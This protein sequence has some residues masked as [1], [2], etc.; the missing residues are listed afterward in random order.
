[1]QGAQAQTL[2]YRNT[3]V[4]NVAG[5]YTDLGTTGTAISMANSDD[6]N[7]AAQNIG[8]SFSYNG[9]SFS[10]FVMNTN[11]AI[12]LGASPP[13][14]AGLYPT[15]GQDA[16]TGSPV[17]S[18]AAADVNLLLPFNFD[19]EAGTGTP[20]Y[21]VAVTGTSPNQVCTIQWKNVSD[22]VK[23]GVPKL[24][25]N[26]SFQI[27]LYEGSNNIEF[28]YDAP[29]LGTTDANFKAAV[30][31]IK[32]SGNG[33][34][35]VAL[36]TKG[37]N[38]AA[39]ATTFL[40]T[41]Y[42]ANGFNFRNNNP[43]ALIDAGRTFRFI[44]NPANDA[45]VLAVYTLNKLPIPV[46]VPHAV[47]AVIANQGSA[48]F[49]GKQATLTIT[50]ASN[51]VVFTNTKTLINAGAGNNAPVTFDPYSPT[52]A[53][54]YTVTVSVPS[55]GVNT[56][57]TLSETQVVNTTGDFSYIKGTNSSLRGFNPGTSV[58]AYAALYT[59]TTALTVNGVRSYLVDANPLAPATYA[60][61]VGKTVYAVLLDA[62]TGAVLGRSNDYVVQAG[63][64]NTLKSFTLQSPV[65]LPA[66]SFLVG[67]A[68]T[69]Q[70][71]QTQVYLPYGAQ[72]ETPSRTG[73]FFSVGISPSAAPT[74]LA[75]TATT[76]M[77]FEAIT[78]AAPA[79]VPP[80]GASAGSITSTGATISFTNSGTA[81][82]YT[83]TV[84][85]QGGSTS[86]VTPAP[87]T[88]PVVLTGLTP[89]TNYTVTI[90]SNCSGSTTSTDA[91]VSFATLYNN[92]AAV[93]IVYTQGQVPIPYG[94][95][96]VVTATVTN[97]GQ[98]TLTNLPVVLTVSGA[99]SFTNTQ[100]VAS[101]AAGAI[102]TV[103]FAG[104]TPTS[105]GTNS[106]VVTISDDNTSNNA[107]PQRQDV[108][109]TT[110]G[111]ATPGAGISSSVGFNT[112]TGILA[113]KFT[114]STSRVVSAVNVFLANSSTTTG[115]TVRAVVLDASGNIIGS[116]AD[117]VV[118]AADLN[119]LKSFTI[120]GT[121]IVPAGS[122]F[123]GLGQTTITGSGYFP[124]GTQNEAP[125]RAGAYFITALTGG[126]PTDVA[127]NNLGRFYIEAVTANLPAC[128]PVSG[129]TTSNVTGTSGDVSFTA[130]SSNTSYTLTY[131]PA[132]GGTPTTVTSS[133]LPISLTGLS[134]GTTYNLSVVS[135]C[136]GGTT[137]TAVTGTLSTVPA[138]D[139]CSAS[140]PLLTC[141]SS[142]TG[143]TRGSTS[144][145][146]PTGTF[147]GNQ[148]YASSGGVFYRF[149]GNG[150]QVTLSMCGSAA[151]YDSELFVFSG[152]CGSLT[153]VASDDDG[154]GGGGLS[155]VTFV[156]NVGTMYYVYVTGWNGNRGNFTLTATCTPL[157]DLVVSNTQGITGV[158]N[159]VT[160]T[161]TGVASMTGDLQVQNAMTVQTGGRLISD[162]TNTIVGAGSFTLAAGAELQICDP[163]GLENNSSSFL[164]VTGT[165]SFSNDANYV[166]NGTN[167]AQLTGSALPS[168]VRSL[169]VNNSDDLTLS[170]ALSVAQLARLQDGDL[171]TGGNTFTLLSSGAGTAVLD[172]TGG[173]VV[174]TGTMQRAITSGASI[175]YRH[176]SSPVQ[177]TTVADLTAPGFTPVV[178]AAYNTDAD[179][180][181]VSPFPTVFGYNQDRIATVTSPYGSFDKGWFSPASLT[182]V[183]QPTRGYTANVPT[184][185]LV[186]F[187]GTFNNGAMPSGTLNRGTDPEAGWHLLG[188]PYPS[189][190]DW[191]TVTNAQRP[192]MDGA[193][194]VYTATSQYR[195]YYRSNVNG[196]GSSPLVDAG[197][198]YFV[199]VTTPGGSGSV[200]L[201]NANRVTTFG[202]QPGF[203]RGTVDTRAKL[204]LQ[205]SGSS[206]SDDAY[207]YFE[208]GATAAV[209]SSFDAVKLANP[210]GLN[211]A[212]LAGNTELAINGLAPLTGTDVIVPLTLRTPQ[213]G[214]YT[215]TAADLANF[216]S[217]TVYLRDAQTGTQVALT[218][219][220]NYRF[221][222][223]STSTTRF[224]LVFRPM[225]VTATQANITADQVSLYPNPAQGRFSVLLPPVAGQKEV[226]ATL[227]NA[228]GQVVLT[229]S[230]ALTAA[231]ATAEIN[232]QGLASGVYVLRLQAQNLTI[233]KRVTVN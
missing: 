159:N 70:T 89:G 12:R 94:A 13:S 85:P 228:L 199:R 108:S 4:L 115:K 118:Q 153:P 172:N 187:V 36:G 64:I 74:D 105:T 166:Y 125:T 45:A 109:N 110:F 171:A 152:S 65:V 213:A 23:S 164:Q 176:Y 148:I 212:A 80:T 205:V 149:A 146:D 44:P 175:G 136:P 119:T 16:I 167:G 10:Q 154:C 111:Y 195:G 192:G 219:G 160:I 197:Q 150:Q 203:G 38:N 215:L 224:S 90:T 132:G 60:T 138:N 198:G 41:N 82:N 133:T 99:N 58:N 211:L 103:T 120:T 15:G 226:K 218:A 179:P 180:G 7:S 1:M 81:S 31:G 20:E 139:Q 69:Y 189:P 165:R 62:T 14:V 84:T 207:V 75:P 182:T 155:T 134:V 18:T 217:A 53:G 231:G 232:V 102:A 42:T 11:G 17:T 208:N 47:R 91:T 230:I 113:S 6:A 181:N 126:T 56:N 39:S 127:A 200:N 229:R 210:S 140:S 22:K 77:M 8:F 104:Y 122:F 117:Y 223:A 101:L 37:S 216:G 201:T 96:H 128:G 206:L 174:G 170:Q 46:A 130:G 161:G 184:S 95:P 29:T 57:N 190:M 25:S 24:F 48:S 78:S 214:S 202:T 116:S 204:Q 168:R 55:D 185:A 21:R 28:V 73:T 220:T 98:N 233:S 26:M 144:T 93:N 32:G 49:S 145:G 35:Q 123:V 61:T 124:V 51:A 66:G 68:Q 158:Y 129:I 114:T 177:S 151:N 186:D 30:V 173:V 112:G 221:T 137:S 33:T 83:V 79:C 196:V 163:Q 169:T 162:C 121:V 142:V 183:M 225:G 34:G 191:S 141:G 97:V 188:N 9:T 54:T 43:A 27:K 222:L 86:T 88:S 72:A 3:N 106:V 227:L 156:S 107:A 92:D 19:L 135:N 40:N 157:P 71:G 178:N 76:R 67:M 209:E 50:D 143:T 194:Y 63:D 59:S 87:T 2:N 193:M 147:F 5:T 131:T 52:V 100:T